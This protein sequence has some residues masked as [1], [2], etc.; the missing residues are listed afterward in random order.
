M[1]LDAD[2]S[3]ENAN[4]FDDSS[5]CKLS[6]NGDLA[7]HRVKKLEQEF[8]AA[9]NSTVITKVILDISSAHNVDSPG[10]ALCV[11]LFKECQ[12]KQL[13]FEI[14]VNKETF[15][16]FCLVNLDRILPLKEIQ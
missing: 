7:G 2:I 8:A 13:A 9:L 5:T 12:A 16:L 1:P 4:L 3:L 10:L 11:G 14:Q 6:I 15:Q